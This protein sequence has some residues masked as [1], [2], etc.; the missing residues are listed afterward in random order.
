MPQYDYDYSSLPL[1]G[2]PGT[3]EPSRDITIP[4]ALRAQVTNLEY[5]GIT[6]DGSYSLTIV[7][8]DGS[9]ATSDAFAAVS[10]TAAQICAGIVA[11][12]LSNPTFAGLISGAEVAT[13]DNVVVSFLARGVEYTVTANVP[14]S[15]PTQ[16]N[17]TEAGYTEV[18]LGIILQ[19]DST[20]GYT[21]TYT[22]AALALGVVI[23]NDDIV[24]P[25]HLSSVEGY[26]GPTQM[27][28]RQ[29]GTVVVD[30]A[31]GVTV[32]RGNKAYFNP[33]TKKWSN[34]TT[35]SHVLVEGAQWRTGATGPAKAVVYVQLPSET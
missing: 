19:A 26:T 10:Q 29:Q 8:D 23:R 7:G 32:Y 11:G 6:T 35:G 15:A 27:T 31:S 17:T 2:S 34:A 18:S 12:C 25:L 1:M 22:D 28:L 5:N 30:V 9:S 13:T 16:S 3:T 24:Q 20:G 4:N 14:G 33:T 21:T